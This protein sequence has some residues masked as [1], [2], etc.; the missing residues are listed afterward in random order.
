MVLNL[1][2]HSC[3]FFEHY[4]ILLVT[5]IDITF[6]SPLGLTYAISN[7]RTNYGIF[8]IRFQGAKVRND[9]SDDVKLLSLKRFK[10]KLKSILI[11][12]N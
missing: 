4:L 5:Y 11:D 9:I 12:K 2:K 8:S 7:A 1:I 3:S 6:G 10:E